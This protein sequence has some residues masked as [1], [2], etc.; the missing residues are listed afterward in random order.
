[1]KGLF[2]VRKIR[3]G[4]FETNSSS[5]HSLVIRR[6]VELSPFNIPLNDKGFVT[7]KFRYFGWEYE[8]LDWQE[9]KLSYLLAMAFTTEIKHHKNQNEQDNFTLFEHTDGFQKLNNF[10]KQYCNG[11]SLDISDIDDNDST[12]E[13]D[14][15]LFVNEHELIDHQSSTDRY[16]SLQDFLDDYQKTIEEIILDDKI[17]IIIDNDNK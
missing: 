17:V 2:D 8:V 12:H 14:A 5:S 3:H 13:A 6:D 4:V 15:Y 11:I 9:D 1:M 7:W 10:V 16:I